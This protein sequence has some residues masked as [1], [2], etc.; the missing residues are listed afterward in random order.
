MR[1][2][3][4]PRPVTFFAGSVAC[5][6]ALFTALRAA[7]F[8]AF[9]A[10]NDPVPAAV[11]AKA[12]YVG[13]KFDLRLAI[14]VNLPVFA[15]GWLP[16]LAL[17]RK[18]A[19][20]AIFRAWLAAANVLLVLVYIV[21][22]G[23]FAYL[24]SRVNVT[25][26]DLLYNFA[27][28]LGMV[29]ETYPV[30]WGLIGI[31]LAGAVVWYLAGRGIAALARRKPVLGEGMAKKAAAVAAA[32]LLA[33]AGIYGKISYYPLRW[34]DAFFS[35][36]P[37][38]SAL[39]LNPV[40]YLAET[41][42][43][44]QKPYE[45]AKVRASYPL[46]ADYLGIGAGD[47]RKLDYT[48]F[49]AGKGGNTGRPNVVIVLLE[50][51]AA[52][53]TGAFGNP[54]SPTPRF[55]GIARKGTLF[56][57]YYTPSAG[58][59]RSV[60]A[61]ITGLPDVETNKT[62]TR[63]PLI[64]TQHT[65]ATA[66]D[67]YGKFYFL[68][69]SLNWANIRGLL[70]H[71]IPGLRVYEEGS[72]SAERV[73]VWGISDLDL[74]LAANAVLAQQTTPFFAVIQTSGSHRPYTIPKNHRGFRLSGATDAQAKAAGF[75]SA[76][77]LDAFRFLDH[78]IGV[79]MDAASKERY[80]RNTVFIFY[81]DHGLPGRAAHISR[82]EEATQ[83]TRVHVPLLV[84]RPGAAEGGEVRDTVASELDVLP[85]AA[86]LA[87]VPYLNSTLGRDLF[88]PAFDRKRFA[89]TVN[90]QSKVAEI[91]LVGER[92]YFVTLADGSHRRLYDMLSRAPEENV[93]DRVP[94]VAREME[95]L[96]RAL[97]ETA[98]YMPYVNAPEKLNALRASPARTPPR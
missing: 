46:V 44:R 53:K 78:G 77:E 52:Y 8:L 21:D 58:T 1:R 22:F 36:S 75:V 7:F 69:G 16:G 45:I 88:D 24:Q 42:A 73:D 67:G 32:T 41:L 85:T 89:F 9:R 90:D 13:L 35:T 83:L 40:L 64:V 12:F 20:A 62:S 14:L 59:A 30:V 98:R 43:R 93:C 34:S 65:I 48:R 2:F 31:L 70:E 96:C 17:F 66:F 19:G 5:N 29:W 10:Q 28:S 76:A 6:L 4:L 26:I 84:Y 79:F 51:F 57:R 54:L 15:L 92:Y 49:V 87:G 60:F 61:T 39:A 97:Y 37:F 68:G 72:Y 3:A 33:A 63:N 81:G 38:A 91:G 74:F 94:E 11:L 95:G 80:F 82:A 47:P 23:H 56:T 55:D 27:T 50:S 71:N 25:V 18:G 86:G